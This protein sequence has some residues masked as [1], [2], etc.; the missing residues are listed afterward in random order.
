ME[1][2]TYQTCAPIIPKLSVYHY[3]VISWM[4]LYHR[5]CTMNV[6]IICRAPIWWRCQSSKSY[7]TIA[8]KDNH[9]IIQPESH[10]MLHL[11]SIYFVFNTVQSFWQNDDCLNSFRPSLVYIRVIWCDMWS[12]SCSPLLHVW[13]IFLAWTIIGKPS[14]FHNSNTLWD[15]CMIFDRYVYQ[16]RRVCCMQ[17]WMLSLA[18]CLNNLPWMNF[19]ALNNS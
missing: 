14:V 7:W 16:T 19:Q 18:S 6:N 2:H 3:S 4:I 15:F 5:N 8:I 1:K 13:M 10:L 17:S 12:N 9:K 11:V